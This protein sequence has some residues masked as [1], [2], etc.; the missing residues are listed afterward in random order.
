[1]PPTPIR[2]SASRGGKITDGSNTTSPAV[3]PDTITL[4]APPRGFLPPGF[5][6]GGIF[7]RPPE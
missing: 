3:D 2:S 7:H 6:S 4:L 1:M 5:L